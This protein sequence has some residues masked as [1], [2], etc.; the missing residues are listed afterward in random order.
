MNEALSMQKTLG[1]TAAEARWKINTLERSSRSQCDR[2]LVVLYKAKVLSY[3]EYRTAAV[4]H[5]IDTVFYV[6]NAVLYTF[7]RKLG[8]SD[9]EALMEFNL[10][11]L[12]V[13]RDIAMWGLIHRTALGEGP[14]QLQH[15]FQR[16]R[17]FRT[18]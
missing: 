7:L 4:Y 13:R 16:G 3:V 6:L 11:P 18:P 2:Q 5:A 14:E 9:L 10:A 17:R 1:K 15:F 8:I 12:E